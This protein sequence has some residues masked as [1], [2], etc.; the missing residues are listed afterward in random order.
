LEE[1]LA[2]FRELG[3]EWGMAALMARLGITAIHQGDC[4]RATALLQESLARRWELGERRGVAECL[5]GLGRV[6]VITDE[7]ESAAR[8]FGAAD[9]LREAIGTP[10]PAADHAPHERS[11]GAV[12]ARLGEDAFAA[13][14]ADGRA[15]APEQAVA[16]A[17]QVVGHTPFQRSQGPIHLVPRPGPALASQNSGRAG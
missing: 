3:D 7:P 14:W 8:L 11:V 16:Y 4:G 9:A 12:R 2:L 1:G 13:A 10:L 5:E 15:T 6:A 17:L